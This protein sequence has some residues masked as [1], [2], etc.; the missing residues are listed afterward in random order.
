MTA[1]DIDPPERRLRV[2]IG[3][4][5]FGP[6]DEPEASAGWAFAT[7]A[8]KDH[9][10][11]VLCRR[12][13]QPEIRAALD[14]DP[15]LAA[16]LT[17]IHID[18]P[19]R[20]RRHYRR[21]WDM[22]WYYVLWQRLLARTARDLH[23]TEQFDVLHHVTFANDWLPSGLRR[24]PGPPFVWGPVGGAT[25]IPY[26]SLRRWLGLRGIAYEVIRDL[27]TTLPRRIWGDANARRADVVV[28][29]NR[30]V[31]RR[32]RRAR[33]VIVE[34][35]AAL[36]L[37]QLPSRAVA[38]RE[39]RA[40]VAVFVGRLIPLKG[41]SIAL[42]ALSR[43]QASDWTLR[44]FGDGPERAALEAM[45]ARLGL[46][47]RVEFF[48]HRPRAEA[49]AAM[50]GADMLLFPSMH[51]QAGWA[52]AEASSM[53]VPVVCLPLGGPP[54]LAEPN[55]FVAGLRGDLVGNVVDQ[56]RAAGVAEG[57]PHARWSRDRLRELT[58]TWYRLAVA[59]GDDE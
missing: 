56:L 37:S 43:P 36:D 28:V 31:A 27:A 29:Q 38:A 14:A 52:V 13:F 48:G 16:H 11:W 6:S 42:E 15:E 39:N 44:I 10:V 26:W 40:P 20:L 57:V 9:D 30:D 21:S 51:D 32:F 46:E 8:A 3:A 4:Y 19:D 34:P 17:V 41:A 49:L 18:L 1:S 22:Y 47:H 2:L 23:V 12:R 54:T 24:V 35:N 45:T 5:A 33:R 50:A 53:G 58:S 7:A 25:D 55:G 59:A